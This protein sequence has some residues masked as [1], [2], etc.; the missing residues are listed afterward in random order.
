LL[1]DTIIMKRLAVVLLG[2]FLSVIPWRGQA[3]AQG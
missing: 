2:L 3:W 1:L